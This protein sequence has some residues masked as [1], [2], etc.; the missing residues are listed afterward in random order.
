MGIPESQL[1]T[2]CNRPNP[3]SSANTYAVIKTALEKSPRL[4]GKTFE[5][6][7]Q[8]SYRNA[9]NIRA[10]SDVDVVVELTSTFNSNTFNL[11]SVEKASYDAR[12]A[13]ATYGWS[14]FRRDVIS[15]L[16]AAFG[17]SAVDT[18][19]NKSIKLAAAPGRL[20]ADVV[21][22][23]E[24]RLY[25]SFSPERYLEGIAFWTQRE[26]RKVVNFPKLHIAN[27]QTKNGSAA[28]YKAGVRMIKN[29]RRVACERGYITRDVAPSY[30]VE[31]FFYNAPDHLFG[32]DRR[33][34]YWSLLDW[35]IDSLRDEKH[36]CGN[37][38]QDLFGPT[39]EQ[40]DVSK[41]ISMLRALLQLE[42]EY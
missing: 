6:Y 38:F 11:S 33:A 19:G 31:C 4:A 20:N 34:M 41:A 35:G 9:T 12:Y 39:P 28:E 15:A 36:K 17:W 42:R 18:T 7:L 37:G 22:A 26:Y 1:E 13:D 32:T 5:V 10:D 29:A 27:G 25:T 2:W 30:F 24:H 23:L 16:Q 21:P 3:A 14:D 40:W 8:G